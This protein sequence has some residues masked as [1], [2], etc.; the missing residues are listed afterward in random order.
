MPKIQIRGK[1]NGLEHPP[2]II[3]ERLKE[4]AILMANAAIDIVADIIKNQRYILET[5]VLDGINIFYE[6]A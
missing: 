6:I 5:K 3:H 1:E 2:F 4:R